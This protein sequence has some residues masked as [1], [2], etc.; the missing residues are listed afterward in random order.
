MAPT[1]G[2][3][4]TWNE[5]QTLQ[6]VCLPLWSG[7]HISSWV[8]TTVVPVAATLCKEPWLSRSTTFVSSF[9]SPV[10]HSC[11]LIAVSNTV[12]NWWINI[13][14]PA[15][16]SS[17]GMA[18]CKSR[19]KSCINNDRGLLGVAYERKSPQE[20]W[21]ITVPFWWS[22]SLTWNPLVPLPST[23]A[24]MLIPLLE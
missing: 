17:P 9:A 22:T 20:P 15:F 19:F 7:L 14:S 16:L 6:Q 21:M 2:A 23:Q 3:N 4:W 5:A 24:M 18:D 11:Q 13:C 12:K 1:E 8:W 10:T